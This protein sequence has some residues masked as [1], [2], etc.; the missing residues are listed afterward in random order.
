MPNPSDI[1]VF[2][3]R[4]I[5]ALEQAPASPFNARQ[6]AAYRDEI[7]ELEDLRDG[8]LTVGQLGTARRFFNQMPAM[9]YTPA[10]LAS[11]VLLLAFLIGT[12][13]MDLLVWRPN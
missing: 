3:Q 2:L 12:L 11:R 4:L 8:H 13:L 5:A 6:V 1:I 9:N 10:Q 7:V